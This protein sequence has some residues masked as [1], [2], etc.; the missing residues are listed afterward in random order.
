[1]IRLSRETLISSGY[2]G[3]D[4][5]AGRGFRVHVRFNEILGRAMSGAGS[6][7]RIEFLS[8]QSGESAPSMPPS[9][10]RGVLL[11]G[12]DPTT[13]PRGRSNIAAWQCHGPTNGTRPSGRRTRRRVVSKSP[14]ASGERGSAS[15]VPSPEAIARPFST[16]RPAERTAP[17]DVVEYICSR[18]LIK[19]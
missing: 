1:M 16:G 4:S 12:A 11:R 18:K 19:K 7:G 14:F 10:L 9:A 8:V 13:S 2:R 15:S 5:W 17:K 6:S 3:P